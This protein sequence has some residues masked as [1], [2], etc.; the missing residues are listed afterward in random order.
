MCVGRKITNIEREKRTLGRTSTFV[1]SGLIGPLR[2]II[3]DCVTALY[4]RVDGDVSKLC[5]PSLASPL[6]LILLL[7]SSLP[8]KT[9][10]IIIFNAV[11]VDEFESNF[12]LI[13]RQKIEF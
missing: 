11:D 13:F 2:L 4:C 9:K 10:S 1:D 3:D 8:A 12:S 5:G 6:V 7:F